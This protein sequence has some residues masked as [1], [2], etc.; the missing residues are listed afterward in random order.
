MGPLLH[1]ENILDIP[2]QKASNEIN[3]SGVTRIEFAR[4]C[5]ATLADKDIRLLCP[6]IGQ[7]QKSATSKG[8]SEKEIERF[9]PRLRSVFAIIFSFLIS[10]SII[11]AREVSLNCRTMAATHLSRQVNYVVSMTNTV[12]D[13]CCPGG[14]QL[15][16]TDGT[17][18]IPDLFAWLEHGVTVDDQHQAGVRPL[19]DAEM[20]MYR[21]HQRQINRNSN[22]G[23][24]FLFHRSW[25]T[26]QRN[27]IFEQCAGGFP[28]RS[29]H[30]SSLY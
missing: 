28:L 17:L 9:Q 2:K 15:W 12:L 26:E 14:S 10:T 18:T 30:V 8:S 7:K 21:H 19:I 20:E 6:S 11:I 5:K 1:R 16:E 13:G 27:E 25:T 22:N 23:R 3:W 29:G 24:L 4:R